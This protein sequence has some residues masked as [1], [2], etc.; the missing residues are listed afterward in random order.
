MKIIDRPFEGSFLLQPDIYTDKRG[1]FS[2]IFNLNKFREATGLNIRFVQDNLAGSFKN[3]FRGMHFQRQPYEQAKLITCL[4]G[5]ILDIIVDLRPGSPTFKKTFQVE[6]SV[7]N[8]YQL[9]VPK[10]FAHGYLALTD[11]VLVMYKTDEFYHPEA[12]G[13]FHYQDP[14][15]DIRLPVDDQVLILSGKD[16]ALPF[17]VDLDL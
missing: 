14:S 5:K 2:E 6:L 8:R 12:D 17:I 11:R 15:V 3:V 1:F 10:G 9:F 4:Q 13:G 16:Q 7:E